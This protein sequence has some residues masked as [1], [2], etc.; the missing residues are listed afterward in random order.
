MTVQDTAIEILC[1]VL[2]TDTSPLIRCYAAQALGEIDQDNAAAITALGIAARQ[3]PEAIVR[4]MAVL[5]IS[6]L[7]RSTQP[8][9][10]MPENNT[11]KVQMT[12]NAPVNY[13]V[14]NV[15]GDMVVNANSSEQTQAVSDM[16]QLLQDLYQ[17]HPHV[18]Q[19]GVTD[20]L[21]TEIKQIQQDQ[22]QRWQAIWRGL[23]NPKRWRSGGKAALIKAGEHF[24]EESLWGKAA[25]A[26]L[27]Q[28]SEETDSE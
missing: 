7:C 9:K 14:G 16:A 27:E 19:A 18:S 17:Q 5:A 3:D 28:F 10:K 25:I 2:L 11:P 8:Q 24:T 6:N 4:T 1:E 13:P 26:F 12:F 20:L 22:P 15:E 21:Q 23:L